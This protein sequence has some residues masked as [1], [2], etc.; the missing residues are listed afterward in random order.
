ME[1]QVL[2]LPANSLLGDFC[3]DKNDRILIG[4]VGPKEQ[5]LIYNNINTMPT[6]ATTFGTEKGIY[7]GVS[8]KHESLKF[9]QIRG[10]GTDDAGNIYIGNTQWHTIGQGLILESYNL[11]T[12]ILNWSK[13]CVVFVDALGID[14]A[15]DGNDVYGQVEHFTLDYS[16][17]TG[18]E[19]SYVGYTV[20]RYK[21][22]HDSRLRIG[23]ILQRV[24]QGMR[25]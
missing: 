19:A 11:S 24:W 18:E 10:I 23:L 8:G 4:D 1:S 13:Y 2:D 7:S 17:P 16:K 14:A 21:Y 20:N 15:S 6:F 22:P 9:N 3:I 5:V 25:T 12:S